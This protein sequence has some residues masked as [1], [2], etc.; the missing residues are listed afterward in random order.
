MSN[1]MKAIVSACS[2]SALGMIAMVTTA[3]LAYI[4]ADYAQQGVAVATIVLIMTIQP[5]VGV[6]MAFAVGPISMRVPK[7]YL[8]LLA[9]ALVVV[10][11][12]IFTVG[13]GKWDFGWLMLASAFTGIVSG[14]TGSVPS[15]VISE[16]TEPEERGKYHG[17]C[18]SCMHAGALVMSF[19]GGWLGAVRWQNAY[20]LYFLAIPAFLI[21]AILCPTEKDAPQ[22]KNAFS[23]QK[24]PVKL[25]LI[26]AKVWL[27]CVQYVVFFICCYT[28]SVYISSYIITDFQLGTSLHSGIATAVV[29]LSAVVAGATYSKYC[30]PLGKWFMPFF[31]LTMFIGYLLC[32]TITTS[33]V[34]V[35]VGAFLVGI[36]KSASVPYLIGE[37]S[38][39]L[40][41]YMIPIGISFVMGSMNLGMFLSNYATGWVCNFLGEVSTYNRFVA[42]AIISVVA[43]I[44]AILVHPLLKDKEAAPQGQQN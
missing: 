44:L 14:I 43:L 11:G 39:R 21:V 3:V 29:T 31:C 13:G 5:L 23:G 2:A 18:N 42:T 38:K 20:Y 10:N 35:V 6:V 25:S 17:Y 8:L 12:F 19:I 41:G 26:P 30:K 1:K 36:G 4:I 28:F 34:G 16:F 15:S 24:P 22:Q 7:K 37:A 27:M 9:M 33:L 40:P 32:C